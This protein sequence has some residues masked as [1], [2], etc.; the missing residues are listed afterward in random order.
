[1]PQVDLKT[2]EIIGFEALV[3]WNSRNFGL[4]PPP[5]FIPLAEESKIIIDLGDWILEQACLQNKKWQDIYGKKVVMAVNL[6]IIQFEERNFVEKIKKVLEKVRLRPEYLELEITEGIVAKNMEEVLKKLSE[7]KNIGVRI[8]I[9]DFG[10]GYSSLSYIKKFPIDK[11]K[12]DR[13]FIKDYPHY[14][15]GSIAKTVIE[16]SHNLD[17]SVIAEGVE[18]EEQIEFLEKNNCD[19]VQGYYFFKPLSESDVAKLF[20]NKY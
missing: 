7:L 16:L 8:A 6:S 1:Q 4:I 15:N 13:S 10:T 20:E 2:K 5:K 12:I 18:T 17:F 9:D 14:D 19:S 3:R 11:I